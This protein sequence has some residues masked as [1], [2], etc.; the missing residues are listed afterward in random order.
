[1]QKKDRDCG[2]NTQRDKDEERD[3]H[4]NH[5][6]VGKRVTT[7]WHSHESREPFV[8]FHGF[9]SLGRCLSEGIEVRPELTEQIPAQ[10]GHQITRMSRLECSAQGSWTVRFL[11]LDERADALG[12]VIG[13]GGVLLAECRANLI[14]TEHVFFAFVGV[15]ERADPIA[16]FKESIRELESRPRVMKT[17]ALHHIRDDSLGSLVE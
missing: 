15:E 12:F 17:V 8:E 1:M 2:D 13:E 14:K 9:Q 3:P 4:A 10:Q 6:A 16:V 5:N 7:G 11:I